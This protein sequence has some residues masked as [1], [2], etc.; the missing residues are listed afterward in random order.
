M[1]FGTLF[2]WVQSNVSSFSGV[3]TS[4][5]TNLLQSSSSLIS[6]LS[7]GIFQGIM[8]GIFTFFMSLE[9]HSIKKFLYEAFPKNISAYLLSREDS[10]LRVLGAW[11]KGQLILSFSI[12][13]LTLL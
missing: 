1:D 2:E 5:S 12:F 3:A 13:A 10:F 7:G 4:L 8:I 9:R 6:T 11:L